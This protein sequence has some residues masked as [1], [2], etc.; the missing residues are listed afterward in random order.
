MRI[1]FSICVAFA[2]AAANAAPAVAGTCEVKSGAKAAALV[3]LYTSEGCSSCPPADQQMRQIGAAAGPGALVVPL[4]LH[5]DYWD[6]IGWKDPFA[7]AGFAARQAR[8]AQ[9]NGQ[10][11][12]YTPQFFVD[13]AELG[14]WRT[15]LGMEIHRANA[16]PA[17]A[18]I[19]LRTA[20]AA[21]GKL[22]VD[23]QAA[24]RSPGA[25]ANLYLAVTESGLST[26]VARGENAGATLDHDHVVR[27]W[28][29]PLPLQDGS[30]RTRREIALPAAWDPAH[31]VVI[32]FVEDAKTAT[33]LQAVSTGSCTA[34]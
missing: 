2:A 8:L 33:V 6:Y 9:R 21:G 13:G 25:S 15:R 18:D 7:Q 14:G 31:L 32:G 11:V 26:K 3:E 19:E 29:G 16:R 28:I 12:V 4:S 1:K 17:R 22:V 23:A 20:I 5:V 34:S 10:G 24:T 27:E 30:A